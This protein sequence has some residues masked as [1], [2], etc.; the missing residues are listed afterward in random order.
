MSCSLSLTDLLG[1]SQTETIASTNRAITTPKTIIIISGLIKG[2][3]RNH[4]TNNTY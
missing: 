1:N 3:F 2:K 4:F